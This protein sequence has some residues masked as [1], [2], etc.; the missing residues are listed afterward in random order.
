[1]DAGVSAVRQ[2]VRLTR[3]ARALTVAGAVLAVTAAAIW[4]DAGQDA[5][6]LVMAVT[7]AVM[8]AT[9]SLF[10]ATVRALRAQEALL[11]HAARPRPDYAVIAVMETEIWGHPFEHAGAPRPVTGAAPRP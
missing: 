7:V 8:V 4:A 9:L 1:V 3:A 2:R 6:A 10:T 5:A 11:A